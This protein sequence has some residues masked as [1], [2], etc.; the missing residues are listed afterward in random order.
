M[1]LFN[2]KGSALIVVA[3]PDDEVLGCGG[4]IGRLVNAG[5]DVNC[6][7]LGGVTSSR[8]EISAYEQEA[9][10][11]AL[12]LGMCL[13]E[14]PNF[15]DNRFDTLPLLDLIQI[16]YQAQK[17]VSPSLVFTHSYSDLNI[18]HRLVHQ[19]V[20]T[21][22]RPMD[23]NSMHIMAFEVLSST[24]YQDQA[25]ASFKPNC[26]VNVTDTIEQKVQAMQCY[27]S[28]L[29][30]FPHPRSMDGIRHLAA[31]RGMQGGFQ[32]A[33]AFQIVREVYA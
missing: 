32:A 12:V 33:E 27:K 16:V 13:L 20:L 21:A 7:I 17:V 22:F 3:H 15:P 6:L 8:G 31:V 24:E 19:A 28:E 23:G 14:R 4:T 25:M 30:E 1:N 5:W 18:D 11:A 9:E 2:S 26:Y 29:H 10:N